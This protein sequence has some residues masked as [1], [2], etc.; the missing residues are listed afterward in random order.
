M[1]YRLLPYI[2]LEELSDVFVTYLPYLY[3]LC[4]DC[5]LFR[6]YISYWREHFISC[7]LFLVF[8]HTAYFVSSVFFLTLYTSCWDICFLLAGIYLRCSFIN[9]I[10]SALFPGVICWLTLDQNFHLLLIISAGTTS[11]ARNS[12][13][14]ALLDPLLIPYHYTQNQWSIRQKYSSRGRVPEIYQRY[15]RGFLKKILQLW[16]LWKGFPNYQ[17][18]P[19]RALLMAGFLMAITIMQVSPNPHFLVL[20]S[21]C[22]MLTV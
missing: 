21:F 18:I 6:F 13:G 4:C 17:V 15:D 11:L 22:F 2:V 14:F 5:H 1:Y 19:N 8:M 10:Y 3:F 9:V 12:I 16:N 7:Y 20:S